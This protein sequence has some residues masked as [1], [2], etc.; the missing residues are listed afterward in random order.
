MQAYNLYM[1]CCSRKRWTA[2]LVTYSNKE[3]ITEEGP[4]FCEFVFK[5]GPKI[6][7]RL[8]KSGAVSRS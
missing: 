6:Q 2:N 4:P 1:V 3:R 5:G 8:R 7:E